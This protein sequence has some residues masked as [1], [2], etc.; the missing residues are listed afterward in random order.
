[1]ETHADLLVSLAEPL[2]EFSDAENFWF[3][4]ME[5]YA[6]LGQASM[7]ASQSVELHKKFDHKLE[8]AAWL[9]IENLFEQDPL[10]DDITVSRDTDDTPPAF[11]YVE[12]ATKEEQYALGAYPD[13]L[14][15]ELQAFLNDMGRNTFEDFHDRLVAL[16][17]IHR[18]HLQSCSKIAVG[19]EWA[20]Q[21][22]TQHLDKAWDPKEARGAGFKPRM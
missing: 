21:R 15:E 12:M 13:G 19:G 2:F 18:E 20:A 10:L 5:I 9:K 4:E 8:Q 14:D 1:M 3:K 16:S 22:A 11:L 6:A 7:T 17:P